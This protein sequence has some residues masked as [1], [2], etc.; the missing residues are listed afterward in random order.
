MVGKLLIYVLEM[1]D[2]R[3]SSF[4]QFSRNWPP[5]WCRNYGIFLSELILKLI[6]ELKTEHI[7]KN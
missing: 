1:S 4:S 7:D 3:V 2:K 5:K 6:Q